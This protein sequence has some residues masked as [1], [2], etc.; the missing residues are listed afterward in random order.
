MGIT[1][2]F[3][4]TVKTQMA[5]PVQMQPF[6]KRKD[7]INSAKK[8]LQYMIFIKQMRN[9]I[10]FQAKLESFFFFFSLE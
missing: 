7:D 9:Q 3:N 2:L 10:E 1:E 8:D 6:K 4:S 5:Q